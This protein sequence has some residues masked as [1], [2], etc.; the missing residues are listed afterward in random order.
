MTELEVSNFIKNFY[1]GKF[2]HQRMGQAFCN[3]FNIT[4]P[5]LFYSL[6]IA[7]CCKRIYAISQEEKNRDSK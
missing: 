1:D 4:N 3:T 5:E 6:D 2:P 7:G